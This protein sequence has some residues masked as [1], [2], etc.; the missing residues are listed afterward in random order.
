MSIS[1]DFSLRSL[2]KNNEPSQNKTENLIFLCRI[3]NNESIPETSSPEEYETHMRPRLY[4]PENAINQ[5]L[6]CNM[7]FC[8]KKKP[9]EY[10]MR[11]VEMDSFSVV[12]ELEKHSSPLSKKEISLL[13][14]DINKK[15]LENA[16]CS[17]EIECNADEHDRPDIS[18]KM[19]SNNNLEDDNRTCLL[20]AWDLAVAHPLI[21]V[22]L[23]GTFIIGAALT[24]YRGFSENQSLP[25][26][27]IKSRTKRTVHGTQ[28]PENEAN[29]MVGIKFNEKTSARCGGT[30]IGKNKIL[31]AAHCVVD[32]SINMSSACKN[33]LYGNTG[34]TSDK[35]NCLKGLIIPSQKLSV[36]HG[37]NLWSTMNTN[38][39]MQIKIKSIDIHHEYDIS[40]NNDY[41]IISTDGD[42]TSNACRMTL[43][44]KNDNDEMINSVV[45]W[46]ALNNPDTSIKPNFLSMGWGM[47]PHTSTDD[48][49]GVTLNNIN[50][51]TPYCTPNPNDICAGDVSRASKAIGNIHRRH[52]TCQND[53]GGP[54]LFLN[55]KSSELIYSGIVSNGLEC[56]GSAPAI[57]ADVHK[58]KAWI[59]SKLDANDLS[60][61]ICNQNLLYNP[62]TLPITTVKPT[63]AAP[64]FTTTLKPTTAVPVFTTTVKPTTAAPVF[65]TTVKP[66]TAAP[67]FTTTVKPTTT[68]PVF[69]TI[70]EPTSTTQPITQQQTNKPNVQ[71]ESVIAA[72][73][74]I[75]TVVA[76]GGGATL[77][78]LLYLKKKKE[79]KKINEV[80]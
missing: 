74:A 33:A 9:T 21:S 20:K 78:S 61:S 56:G 66:T 25:V 17:S 41:A 6:N 3:C 38:T 15:L 14:F 4:N 34:L 64:V 52:D 80:I 5:R 2:M 42:F 76:L 46:R 73:S 63:T 11:P 49:R 69:T 72:G 30:I 1:N 54:L 31:T 62:L 16:K 27:P 35:Y 70:V 18:E 39:D 53:S 58:A 77:A 13:H 26:N 67:V 22:P 60:L 29:Y 51:N 32:E 12:N 19:M 24:A 59:K 10:N 75:T 23:A 71:I 8:N 65:T 68:A 48:L 57:Y 79:T 37:S 55:P 40:F 44:T 7:H 43:P 36:L 28:I 47:D 45:N 50:R